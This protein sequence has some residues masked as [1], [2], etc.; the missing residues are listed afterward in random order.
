MKNKKEKERTALIIE[1]RNYLESFIKNKQN[2]YL[3]ILDLS[4]HLKIM[5]DFDKRLKK[6]K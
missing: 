2:Q 6:L 4:N 3:H 1:M 5:R